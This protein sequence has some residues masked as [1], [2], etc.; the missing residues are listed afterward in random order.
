MSRLFSCLAVF[1][2]TASSAVMAADA[3]DAY[4]YS[5]IS[6][7]LQSSAV[8][9]VG[10]QPE[11][12]GFADALTQKIDSE[13]VKAEGNPGFPKE[14]A[15]MV[16]DKV[17][18]ATGNRNV[19]SKDVIGLIG[20]EFEAV[21]VSVWMDSTLEKPDATI[22][23][24]TKFDPTELESFLKFVP[25]AFYTQVRK[26]SNE[27]LY[28]FFS[29]DGKTPFLGFR[30]VSGSGSYVIVIS[31]KQDR[32]EQQL[33][34]AKSGDLGKMVLQQSGPF[35]KIEITS[36]FIDKAREK[37]VQEVKA[38]AGDDPNAKNAINILENLESIALEVGDKDDATGVKLSI[39]MK[40]EED[41]KNLKE[42]AEGF[43]ALLKMV[44]AYNSDI[45][46]NGKKA[47]ALLTKI[48]IQ[49]ESKSVSAYLN[50][51]QA[52]IGDAVKEILTK[53][54]AE[55]KK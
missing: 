18:D 26:D 43:I 1:V 53:V 40:K 17:R 51:N 34:L 29:P 19:S 49:Q 2:M 32:V 44:A 22:A 42:A 23:I 3:P 9:W 47:I 24:F 36:T 30:N 10:S 52:E 33:G 27:T 5:N 54:T 39:L 31:E 38:K 13:Y 7:G 4:F 21:M 35:K 41:A 16:L 8:K 25:Q 55:L 48:A 37:A 14:L 28:K 50:L 45:D 12:K 46:E 15:D 20:R 6:R 11:W